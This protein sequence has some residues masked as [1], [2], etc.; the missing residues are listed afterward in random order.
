[1]RKRE[2]KES[3]RSPTPNEAAKAIA[4]GLYDQP[5]RILTV[6]EKL[7]PAMLPPIARDVAL[8]IEE[9]PCLAD[10]FAGRLVYLA[11]ALPLP[12][13]VL[14][15]FHWLELMPDS[16][17]MELGTFEA[18]MDTLAP[19]RL[20]FEPIGFLQRWRSDLQKSVDDQS[21]DKPST[22]N[23]DHLWRAACYEAT[24]LELER[25]G[26]N[27]AADATLEE[28]ARAFKAG[29]RPLELAS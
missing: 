9:F 3:H 29:F 28:A 18:A 19:P 12:E 7:D 8:M 27:S 10:A 6:T 5:D 24:A 4:I 22:W 1:M 2:Q 16:E 20:K 17:R 15:T 25:A 11:H 23:L 21:A 14:R 26:L 13:P